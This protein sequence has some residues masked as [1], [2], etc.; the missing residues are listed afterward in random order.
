MPGEGPAGSNP[1]CQPLHDKRDKMFVTL[2]INAE[3]R[4]ALIYL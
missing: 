3:A 4:E 1:I 2:R